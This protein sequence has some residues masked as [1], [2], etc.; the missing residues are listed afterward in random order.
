M[1][2]SVFDKMLDIFVKSE[3]SGE[4]GM[5]LKALLCSDDPEKLRS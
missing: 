4:A 1:G 5:Y 2:S 3:N